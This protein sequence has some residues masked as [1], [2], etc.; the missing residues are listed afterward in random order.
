[1]A[2]QSRRNR[3]KAP[4]S[5][6]R[7]STGPST[8]EGERLR[9]QKGARSARGHVIRLNVYGLRFTDR[10]RGGAYVGEKT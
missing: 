10:I 2:L 4:P 3:T 9:G 8:E 7:P 5:S 6:V 1:M